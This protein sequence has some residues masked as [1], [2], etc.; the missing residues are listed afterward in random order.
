MIG[1]KEANESALF[2]QHRSRPPIG[3]AAKER[4]MQG[5]AHWFSALLQRL[6]CRLVR[7]F[8]VDGDWL[9]ISWVENF[10]VNVVAEIKKC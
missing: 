9:L 3:T 10:S 1:C 4:V 8:S 5:L 7:V 2:E 6:C